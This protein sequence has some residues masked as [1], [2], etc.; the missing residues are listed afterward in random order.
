[1]KTLRVGARAVVIGT[2]GVTL[3]ISA[4]AANTGP[5]NDAAVTSGGNT[6]PRA[7]RPPAPERPLALGFEADVVPY[8]LSGAHLDA[9]LGYDGWRARAIAVTFT[10]PSFAVPAGFEHEH[11]T[12]V[13]LEVDRFF[14][15]NAA[16]FRGPWVAAGGGVTWLSVSAK[17]GSGQGSTRAPELSLGAGWAFPLKFGLYLNPWLGIGYQFTPES[18]Q[19]GNSSFHPPHFVPAFG[20]K[21]GW[22]IDLVTGHLTGW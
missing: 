16:R 4:G 18:L 20:F 5:A 2:L 9:S 11:S 10:L 22:D 13:E 3:P 1:M 21:L 12:L 17:D 19:V 6:Q 15:P 7:E 14:G 8:L